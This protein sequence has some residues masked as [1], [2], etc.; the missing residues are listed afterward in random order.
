MELKGVSVSLRHVHGE[1][2]RRLQPVI[3]VSH[4]YHHTRQGEKKR[5]NKIG[6]AISLN[7]CG[8]L[9]ISYTVRQLSVF[10]ELQSVVNLVVVL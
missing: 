3:K 2:G 5:V 10:K 1:S 6:V 9:V 8:L 4:P 7:G